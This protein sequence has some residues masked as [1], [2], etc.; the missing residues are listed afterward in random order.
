MSWSS[1]ECAGQRDDKAPHSLLQLLFPD[2]VLRSIPLWSQR[3]RREVECAARASPPALREWVPA[4]ADQ[5]LY[6][7]I[8]CR[9]GRRAECLRDC[10]VRV[11]NPAAVSAKVGLRLGGL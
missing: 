10:D 2:A 11:P 4:G 6:A 5:S 8:G 3:D 1:S 7:G 9:N